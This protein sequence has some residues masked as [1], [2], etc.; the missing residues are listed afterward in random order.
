MVLGQEH[1][2]VAHVLRCKLTHELTTAARQ[3]PV[4]NPSSM[5][6][7]KQQTASC[8]ALVWRTPQAVTKCLTRY[9]LSYAPLPNAPTS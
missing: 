2:H 9:Q 6:Q 8:S 7:Q 5:S 3:D 1:D 4:R